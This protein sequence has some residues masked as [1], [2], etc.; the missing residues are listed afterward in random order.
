VLKEHITMHAV[1]TLAEKSAKAK[2]QVDALMKKF[3]VLERSM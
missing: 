3:Q 2:T 1:E